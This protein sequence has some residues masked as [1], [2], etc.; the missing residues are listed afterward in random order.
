MLPNIII[1]IQCI[2]YH[3][4]MFFIT[5]EIGIAG[6]DEN[7]FDIVLFDIAGIG[8]LYA[9][10]VFIGYGLFVLA[11]PFFDVGLQFIHGCMQ[12]YDLEQFLVKPELF[13]GQVHFWQR[14]GIW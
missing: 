1:F 13:L 5:Q 9:E 7:G 10:Q 3:L 8:F 11:I 12:V 2:Q 4:Q 14:A 6:V